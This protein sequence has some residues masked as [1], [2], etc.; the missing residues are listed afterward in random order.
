MVITT[1]NTQQPT[2]QKA[3]QEG[4]GMGAYLALSLASFYEDY[5]LFN[6]TLFT[7]SNAGLP[8][9]RILGFN[10]NLLSTRLCR[11]CSR[12]KKTAGLWLIHRLKQFQT[13]NQLECS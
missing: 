5:Q 9:V 4:G 1:G 3:D 6:K 2:L 13:V 12:N 7:A 11:L 8:L 10:L